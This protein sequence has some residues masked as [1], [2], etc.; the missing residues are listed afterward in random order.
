MPRATWSLSGGRPVV[1]IDLIS[2]AGEKLT[3][4]LLADTGAGTNEAPFELILP[5]SDCV[6]CGGNPGQPVVLGGAY[7]GAFPVYV[8]RVQIEAVGF[9]QYV[10]A[11]SVRSSPPDVDGLAC[12]RFLNRFTYGNFGDNARFGLER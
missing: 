2:T 7:T 12:F 10:R 8:I 5:D 6:S 3:R 4:R 1:E 11:V 9:D